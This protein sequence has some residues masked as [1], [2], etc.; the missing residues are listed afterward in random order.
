MTTTQAPGVTITPN[1]NLIIEGD[2]QPTA[3]DLI[4]AEARRLAVNR[5][6]KVA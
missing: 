2:A 3:R 5:A 1:G 6:A 4:R